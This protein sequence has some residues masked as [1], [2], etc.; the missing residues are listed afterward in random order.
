MVVEIRRI[1]KWALDTQPT[2]D[3]QLSSCFDPRLEPFRKHDVSPIGE[4]GVLKFHHF[5]FLEETKF[6]NFN[7]GLVLVRKK[8]TMSTYFLLQFLTMKLNLFTCLI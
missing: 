1:N 6:S 2:L 8:V 3:P 4:F 5:Y 7:V